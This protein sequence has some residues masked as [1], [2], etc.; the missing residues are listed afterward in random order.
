MTDEIV[1]PIT[2]KDIHSWTAEEMRNKRKNPAIS[3]EID[4]VLATP[5]EDQNI[6]D[7]VIVDNQAEIEAEAARVAAEAEAA[8]AAAAEAETARLAAE[9]ETARLAQE[10]EAARLAALPVKK[11][12]IVLDYQVHDENGN[13]IGRKTHL[14]ADSWQEMSEKQKTAH[15]EATRAYERLKKRQAVPRPKETPVTL[16]SDDD[17]I[18][19]ANDLKSDDLERVQAAQRKL[20]ADAIILERAEARAERL[21]AREE[22]VAYLFM[23]DHLHDFNPCAANAQI[24]SDYLKE[25]ELEWTLDNIE[26]AFAATEPQLAPVRRAPAAP[27]I[28]PVVDN[29]PIPAAT[30][31]VV[32]P[33]APVAP[34]APPVAAPNAPAPVRKLADGG[35]IP[36]Q[37]LTGSRPVPKPLALTKKDI[38]KMPPEE[39]R[40]KLR[41]IPGFRE[42]VTALFAQK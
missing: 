7:S 23:R 30:A 3:A 26:I 5:R 17:A 25:N 21:R 2:R 12:K 10:E 14:E 31:P 18:A 20:D 38:A 40:L 13:P 33:P 29:T 8:Q 22:Q 34:P 4:A 32:V 35:L 24:L 15:T 41:T 16:M 42:Q 11:E 39:M 28:Q 9:A 1:V 36:G 19:A 37:T 6:I 27:V